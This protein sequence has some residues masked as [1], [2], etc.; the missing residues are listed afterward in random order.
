MARIIVMLKDK[1]LKEVHVGREPLCIGRD[2]S[3]QLRLDNPAV[4]RFHA[5]V[6]RQGYPYFVEDKKSTN[7]TFV[8][9]M[10]V[11]WKTGL[12]D[13]DRITVGKHTLVFSLDPA[14]RSEGKPPA[15]ADIDGTIAIKPGRK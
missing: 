13:G 5:E 2:P 12:K 9:E 15:L 14:D 8:N 7:G 1:V 10:P 3:N 4:S 6:Y 11:S